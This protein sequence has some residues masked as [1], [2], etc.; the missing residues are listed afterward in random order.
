MPALNGGEVKSFHH[1]G[2][3][4]AKDRRKGGVPAILVLLGLIPAFCTLGLGGDVSR[5][6]IRQA[7]VTR[8]QS[9][10]SMDG[11]LDEPDWAKARSIG[12]LVQREPQPTKPATERTEVKLLHDRQNLYVGVTAYDSEPQ[13]IVATQMKRDSD[14]RADDRI[15]ILLDTFHDRRNAFYFATNPLGTLVDGLVIENGDLN[16]DFDA[17]WD[18]HVHRFKGGWSAEFV[19]PFESL[20]FHKGQTVWGFNISRTIKRKI[21]EDRWTSARL[22]TSFLQ[23]SEAGEI[24]GLS[25]IAQ[26]IGLDIRPFGAGSYLHTFDPEKDTLTGK[27]GL[28]IFY[29]LTPSLKWTGTINTDFG[30]TEVDARQINLTRFPL[31][32]PEKR[33]FF[34]EDAGVFAFSNTGRDIIPFFSRRI[35]LLSDQQ[36]PI[37]AGAKLTGRAGK[38]DI[39]V[40]GVRTR[41]AT[42]LVPAKTFLVGRLRRNF[43]RQSYIGG[44]FTSGDPALS[45]SARTFGADLRLA[46]AQFMGRQRNF[47]VEAFWLMTANE[48]V[49]GK[50]RAFGF[51]ASY[52]NDFISASLDWRQIEENFRP[53]LGF[54]SR[55]RV[56]RLRIAAELDPR[57]RGLLDIRQMFHEFSFTRFTRLDQG[58]TESWRVFTAPI[59]WRFDSGDRIELNYIPQFERLFE[60]FEISPGVILPPGDYRFTRY[61]AEFGTASKRR[62]QVRGTWYFGEYWSGRADEIATTFRYKFPPHFT[63][64]LQTDQSFARLPQGRFTTR[65]FT[66]RADQSFT[67][68]ITLSN[69]LQFDNESRNL[70]WQSRLRWILQPG[71]ELFLVFNQ[72][73]QQDPRGGIRFRPTSSA[74][75]VKFQHTFRF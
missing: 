12:D 30:E 21:E 75:T 54:V 70:G 50:D 26:G 31:F 67:P 24:T 23:V 40:L 33:S 29:N 38:Y 55:G 25:E 52:P 34:L 43:F 15:E 11:I 73:D 46:T 8:I 10:I 41:E 9:P 5:N 49:S 7:F 19:I 35:G 59:N 1:N 62:W 51:S 71:N 37:Q 72:G 14:L 63:I 18:V 60:P 45:A 13:R 16:T 58:R 32:F 74:L 56:R 2:A 3:K 61:R 22:E 36:V 53:A 47:Q 44:I 6:E 65:I 17:I 48:G 20:S 57:P 27:P 39:G 42:G 68:F 66:L 69:L 28:D 4:D 64:S